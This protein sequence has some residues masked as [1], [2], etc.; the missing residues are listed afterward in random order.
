MIAPTFLWNGT[1]IE[2][3]NKCDCSSRRDS[4]SLGITAGFYNLKI[5]CKLSWRTHLKSCWAILTSS[6][7]NVLLH[8]ILILVFINEHAKLKGGLHHE[9]EYDTEERENIE[10]Y[11]QNWRLNYSI[12]E[13]LY[14]W[15]HTN[16]FRCF[17]NF[18]WF[19]LT[20]CSLML[21]RCSLY[22]P[23]YEQW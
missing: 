22:V 9:Q 18:R 15:H 5:S 17:G 16:C 19:H 12:Y 10:K 3:W 7:I 4:Y 2:I 21:I 13:T 11:I 6:L 8:N 23:V 14:C 20:S 1:G